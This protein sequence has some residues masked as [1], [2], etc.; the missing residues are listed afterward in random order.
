MMSNNNLGIP[1]KITEPNPTK[2][3]KGGGIHYY[4]KR[5]LLLFK[6]QYLMSEMN[7]HIFISW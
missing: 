4:S 6:T 3:K 7:E 2:K 1:R 5:F